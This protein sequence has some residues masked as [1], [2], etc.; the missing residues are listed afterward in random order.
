MSAVRRAAI[1]AA[2]H[3]RSLTVPPTLPGLAPL[4]LNKKAYDN[5]TKFDNRIL[6]LLSA[7]F[8]MGWA[9]SPVIILPLRA[10]A[11]ALASCWN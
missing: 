1:L 2:Y 7:R 5:S 10:G 6:V 9:T 8:I 3:S 11:A 4:L